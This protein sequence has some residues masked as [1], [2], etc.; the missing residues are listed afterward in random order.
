MRKRLAEFPAHGSEVPTLVKMQMLVT[1]SG[2]QVVAF[3]ETAE[4]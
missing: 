2:Q 1:G 3:L 4:F